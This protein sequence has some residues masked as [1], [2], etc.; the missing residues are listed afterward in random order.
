MIR[1]VVFDMD[2]VLIDAKDW[3]YEALNRALQHFGM[4]I[5]RADHLTTFDGLPTRRKLEMLTVTENLPVELHGFLNKL[6]QIY[7]LEIVSTRC[8]PTFAHE[9]ALS[10]LK[11]RGLRLAVA[12]NSVR[13]SVAIMME[14][15][16]LAAHLD[17]T[18]SNEDVSK[19]KPD[20]EIY[21]TALARL[22]VR[23]DE[24]LIVEDNEHGIRAARASGCHLLVVR[25]VADVTLSNIDRRI[26]EIE[27][28]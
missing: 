24:T 11:A 28:A 20:P 27:A 9:F 18:L 21:T 1:A 25:S 16:N 6:K 17:L 4:E 22:G 12:S 8:R 7:T 3:H 23:A 15:A 5:S 26:A 14:R 2:G 19:A 13:E 10:R